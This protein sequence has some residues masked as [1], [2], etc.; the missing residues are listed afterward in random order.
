MRLLLALFALTLVFAACANDG[1]GTGPDLEIERR[2]GFAVIVES[3]ADGASIGFSADRDA[4][5][6]EEFDVTE[7][8]WRVD[9]GPWTEPP[10]TCLGKG[11][12]IELGISQVEN[13]ERPGLLK[14]RVVWVACLAPKDS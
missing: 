4:V 3:R 14:D 1:S 5:S 8:V 2:I 7:S 10:V 9:D 13:E 12:R 6:G 11:Q